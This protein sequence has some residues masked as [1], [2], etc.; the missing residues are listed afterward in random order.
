MLNGRS[1]ALC[2]KTWHTIFSSWRTLP[3]KLRV[4]GVEQLDRPRQERQAFG[5]NRPR[6]GAFLA[7]DHLETLGLQVADDLHADSIGDVTRNHHCD[8]AFRA[9]L[10]ELK[11]CKVSNQDRVHSSTFDDSADYP[12]G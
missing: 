12:K 5:F 6:S 7:G 1:V 2:T 11:V 8:V 4:K 3:G 9:T 10:D